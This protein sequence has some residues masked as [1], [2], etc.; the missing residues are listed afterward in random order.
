MGRIR[1]MQYK[2]GRWNG[3]ERK[4]ALIGKNGWRIKK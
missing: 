3:H 1:G 4:H 2:K